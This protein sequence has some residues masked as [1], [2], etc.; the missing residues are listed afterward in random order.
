M[1]PAVWNAKGIL[2]SHVKKL[3]SRATSHVYV[4]LL[5]P[6]LMLEIEERLNSQ[7]LFWR[8]KT[9]SPELLVKTGD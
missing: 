6:E 5:S 2:K 7:K 4:F 9:E 1:L 3:N 8:L